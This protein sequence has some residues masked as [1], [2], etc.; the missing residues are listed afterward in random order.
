[1]PS[2]QLTASTFE[3]RRKEKTGL[4]ARDKTEEDFA[5]THED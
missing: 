1:V 2:R 3:S 5:Y 4:V